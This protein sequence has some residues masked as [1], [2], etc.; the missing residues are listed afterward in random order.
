MFCNEGLEGTGLH[1]W[2]PY[3]T[4]VL[5]LAYLVQFLLSGEIIFLLR[6]M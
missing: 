6:T 4:L 2:Q 5:W 3:C 1:R